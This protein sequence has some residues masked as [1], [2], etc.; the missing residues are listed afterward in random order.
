[1]ETFSDPEGNYPVIDEE[2][3]C[4]ASV[5]DPDCSGLLIYNRDRLEASTL[6]V[7]LDATNSLP[8][9]PFHASSRLG[10]P[11]RLNGSRAFNRRT[12]GWASRNVGLRSRLPRSWSH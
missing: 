1:M 8:R 12:F 10:M 3:D 6:W 5:T 9:R 2:K 7:T 11:P 4:H